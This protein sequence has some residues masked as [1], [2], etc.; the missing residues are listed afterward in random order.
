MDLR[1]K[2]MISLT[3]KSVVYR[4]STRSLN[5]SKILLKV[6]DTKKTYLSYQSY[7]SRNTQQELSLRRG[8][9]L[10][11]TSTRRQNGVFWSDVV[12]RV[13][14]SKYNASPFPH[15]LCSKSWGLFTRLA[16]EFPSVRIFPAA[17]AKARLNVSLSYRA[18]VLRGVTERR[19]K[20]GE[21]SH[22]E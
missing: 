19:N 11:P 10:I 14:E 9:S 6:S 20:T 1:N 12:G 7:N 8:I 4:F 13:A 2:P 22:G 15:E 21:A 16:R 5:G 17:F 18:R 3:E